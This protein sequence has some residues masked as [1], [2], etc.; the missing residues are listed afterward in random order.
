MT[1]AIETNSSA[2]A[3][4]AQ[5]YKIEDYEKILFDG[6]NYNLPMSVIEII[7]T[8]GKEI[9]IEQPT[10]T[11]H[12]SDDHKPKK[13]FTTTSNHNNNNRKYNKHNN[14]KDVTNEDWNS[15]KT[16]FKSTKIEKKEGIEK[17]MN[18]I[19][20]CLNKI[21]NKN[22]EL[23]RNTIIEYIQTIMDEEKKEFSDESS[24][25]EDDEENKKTKVENENSKLIANAIFDIASN[26][27]FYSELYASL[28]KDLIQQFTIF[29][30]II[31][32]FIEQY[33]DSIYNIHYVDQN[34]DYDK[35]CDYNKFNDRR[36]SLSNFIVNLM[37]KDVLKKSNTMDIIM[38]FQNL[39]FEYIEIPNK[40]NEVEEITENLFILVTMS[41][42]TCKSE[43][44]WNLIVENIKKCSQMKSKEKSSL[45]NRAIFKYM[46][47]L[48]SIS[49]NK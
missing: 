25:E 21:S 38:K 39:I 45:T 13:I 41:N 28:Y 6:L 30:D 42:D 3:S 29:Y 44:E 47:I 19:R 18:D 16:V 5:M 9:I 2:A 12:P 1:I 4:A 35:F 24:E 14:K 46:D 26:N 31:E 43:D 20:I 10:S 40:T 23:Q 17:K 27:K 22:Y 8:L 48:D 32:S 33:S 36:K 11:N 15:I 49:K 34:V 7:Q 37:K